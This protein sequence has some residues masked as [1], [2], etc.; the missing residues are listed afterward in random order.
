MKPNLIPDSGK[1]RQHTRLAVYIVGIKEGKIL[2]GKRCNT[3]HMDGMWSPFA[4]HVDEFESLESA[5]CREAEEELGIKLSPTD[6]TLAGAFH[7]FSTPHDYACYVYRVNLDPYTPEN[8]EPH[9][10]EQLSFFKKEELPQEMA[11]YIKFML[12]KTLQH[13]VW[14][15]TYGWD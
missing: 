9:K 15:D 5:L 1:H 8:R 6:Y 14:I 13:D 11:E 12:H 10:C 7:H 4:G 3:C 2:L